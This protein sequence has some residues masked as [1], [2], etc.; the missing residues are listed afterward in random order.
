MS[1]QNDG[2]NRL[3]AIPLDARNN[4]YIQG[5]LNSDSGG[6]PV[7]S[8]E[9]EVALGKT[10]P[11]TTLGLNSPSSCWLEVQGGKGFQFHTGSGTTAH[12]YDAWIRVIQD[13][14]IPSGGGRIQFR[15]ADT[16][17][18]FRSTGALGINSDYGTALYSITSAGPGL[19]PISQK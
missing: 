4:A 15:N 2:V 16:F 13:Q 6:T 12:D 3:Q 1:A 17:W 18:D 8:T 9:G 5:K 10:Q 7:L 11:N 19:P 14:D